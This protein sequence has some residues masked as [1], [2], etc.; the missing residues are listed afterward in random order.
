[1]RSW[2]LA[3]S[4]ESKGINRDSTAGVLMYRTNADEFIISDIQFGQYG[5]GLKQK[6]LQVAQSDGQNTYI[7]IESGTVGGASKFLFREY[8]KQLMGYVTFQSEPVG[9]KVDRAYA[10]RQAILD[11]KVHVYIQNDYIRG[12]LIK[13]LTS[14]PLGKHDDIIDACAYGF[15]WLNKFYLGSLI[16][17]S[18]KRE[19]VKFGGRI[20]GR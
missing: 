20:G 5:E 10:F 4:D 11:G 12:E 17:T 14:F 3:Y 15:N 9:S 13:Q 6:L 19:R 2:D 1:M 8:Q 16:G 7:L 18:S